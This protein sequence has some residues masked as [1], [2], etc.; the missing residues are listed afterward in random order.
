[1]KKIIFG[2]LFLTAVAMLMLPACA[3]GEG[4]KAVRFNP[5]PINQDLTLMKPIEQPEIDSDETTNGARVVDQDALILTK[6]N[7]MEK[8]I[9][10]IKNKVNLIC[11]EVDC[12]SSGYSPGPYNP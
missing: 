1:M 3:T 5:Q 2:I 9:E 12:E 10:Y 11:K 4:Y 8:D 7:E 6:L